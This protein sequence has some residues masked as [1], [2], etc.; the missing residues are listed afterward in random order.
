MLRA[1]RIAPVAPASTPATAATTPATAATTSATAATT[2]ATAATTP[3]TAATTPATAA[4]TPATA[5]TTPATA[6]TT[7]A[8]AATLATSISPRLMATLRLLLLEE[9]HLQVSLRRAFCFFCLGAYRAFCWAQARTALIRAL[10]PNL[11]DLWVL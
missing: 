6:A 10:S 8:T 5:A 3:A 11:A 9:H 7:P 2:P 4:T 1:P